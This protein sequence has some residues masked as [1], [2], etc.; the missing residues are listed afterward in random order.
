MKTRHSKGDMTPVLG[1]S[2]LPEDFVK[3]PVADDLGI[4]DDELS[5]MLFWLVRLHKDKLSLKFRNSD[6]AE[7]NDET[8]R[9]LIDDIHEALGIRSDIGDVL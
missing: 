9:H 2:P 4:P 6:I 1:G 7:M 8:K 3:S 5:R